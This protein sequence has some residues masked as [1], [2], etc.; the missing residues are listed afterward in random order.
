MILNIILSLTTILF[1]VLFLLSY[2]REKK[3]Y[4]VSGEIMNSYITYLNKISDLVEYSKI[5]LRE[6]DEKGSFNSDDE[7]GFFFSNLLEIQSVLN[8]FIIKDVTNDQD[9]TEEKK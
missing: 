8:N 1:L 6:I 2:I 3:S 9:K 4:K 7:V 5:K